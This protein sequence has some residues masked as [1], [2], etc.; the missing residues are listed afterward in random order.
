MS[1]KKKEEISKQ[2]KSMHL[3]RERERATKV[4][5]L[6][7]DALHIVTITTKNEIKTPILIFSINIM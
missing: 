5:F 6:I 3:V 4:V 7:N 1:C 2:N